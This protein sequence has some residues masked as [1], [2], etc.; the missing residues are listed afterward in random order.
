[1]G[2]IPVNGYKGKPLGRITQII[3]VVGAMP[4]PTRPVSLP[5][6]FTEFDSFVLSDVWDEVRCETDV[7]RALPG[8]RFRRLLCE[9]AILPDRVAKR[10]EDF[11]AGLRAA[12]LVSV[13]QICV[14]STA[15]PTKFRFQ[16]RKIADDR[17]H[18]VSPRFFVKRAAPAEPE[19]LLIEDHAPEPQS[20]GV[21]VKGLSG[22]S[23]DG[24]RDGITTTDGCGGLPINR[25]DGEDLI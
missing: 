3:P 9:Q 4:T 8:E 21:P 24:V 7:M 23:L 14:Q 10:L 22:A 5:S 2:T 6:G 15:C 16:K 13:D 11:E 1:M 17:I 18:D 12:G 20:G 25:R 19:A